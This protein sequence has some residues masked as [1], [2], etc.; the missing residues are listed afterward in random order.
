MR[1]LIIEDEATASARLKRM[2][3]E[4]RPAATCLGEL[5]GV[6]DA[7]H[8]FNEHSS[9]TIDVAFVDIQLSDGVSFE[10]FDLVEIPFPIIFTT[11]YDQYALQVFKVHTIDYLLKPIKQEQL[12]AALEKFERYGIRPEMRALQAAI[13]A[14]PAPKTRRRFVVKTGR[15]I[16]VVNIGDISYF[17]SENKITYLVCFDG[18]RYAVDEPLDQLETVLDNHEFYRANR[19]HIVSIHGISE[20]QTYSRSRLKLILN[21]PPKQ[22]VIVSTEKASTFKAWLRGKSA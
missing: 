11:A 9:E 21:P 16:R 22:D 1:F 19:Q 2:I 4:L 6:E 17:Y 15:S 10:L 7:V 5:R 13:S 12:E 20:M 3:L 8:W 18:R 14:M